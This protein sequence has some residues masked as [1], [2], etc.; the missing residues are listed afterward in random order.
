MTTIFFIPPR[1][2]R[3]TAASTAAAPQRGSLWVPFLLYLCVA[4]C[5]LSDAPGF[6]V[7]AAAIVA[8]VVGEGGIVLEG[9]N[10]ALAQAS[11]DA[12]GGDRDS[13]SSEKEEY[14]LEGCIRRGNG[15]RGARVRSSVGGE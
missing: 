11:A 12:E 4:H 1:R 8:V 2:R 7:V 5:G 10:S 15:R 14:S 6:F 13:L 3:R 9:V